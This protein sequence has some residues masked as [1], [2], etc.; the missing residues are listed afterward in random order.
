MRATL[1]KS[2]VVSLAAL[3][4]VAGLSASVTPA[5]AWPHH[6][7]GGFGLGLGVGLGLGALGGF[8]ASQPGYAYGYYTP[9][10]A[11]ARPTTS[12]A[13]TSAASRS[14]SADDA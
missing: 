1:K 13:I 8:A 10:S 7:F 2:I 5:A 6:G 4:L 12:G 9:A 3:T 14:P 11:I